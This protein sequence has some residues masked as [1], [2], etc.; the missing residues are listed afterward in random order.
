MAVRVVGERRSQPGNGE[1]VDGELVDRCVR[2]AG[3]QLADGVQ[4]VGVASQPAHGAATLD[5]RG[6]SSR[7]WT[8]VSLVG[9]GVLMGHEV[10]GVYSV[11]DHLRPHAFVADVMLYD[12]VVMPVPPGPE[13]PESP[14][15]W[16]RWRTEGWDPEA[17]KSILEI[18]GD[19]AYPV[20]WGA[21]KRAQ[22]KQE[23]LAARANEEATS[24]W[25]VTGGVLQRGLPSHVTGINAVA[26]YGS[27]A[28]L[29]EAVGLGMIT[30]TTPLPAG[31]MLVVMGRE[32][33]APDHSE[34]KSDA[35][36][37]KASVELAD[38]REFRRKRSSYWRWQREFLTDG[39][40]DQAAIKDA[41]EEMGD[42]LA[43]ELRTVRR[44]RIKTLT[45]FAFCV[46]SAAISLAAA[47]FTPLALGA[48]F[49]SVG[50]FSAERLLTAHE[51]DVP[52]P[53]ALFFDA[54]KQLGW[55]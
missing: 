11:R 25:I 18:L 3:E 46:S 17:Q 20:E 29:E 28:E 24:P 38:D 54:R 52:S 39:I 13:S 22:W 37:L 7:P 14:V 9:Q 50:Q 41:A 31:Q 32:F 44:Q 48:A 45:L 27:R 30:D 10:W 43:D 2:G 42:L 53:T 49:L 36:L 5:D 23:W 51:K 40:T 21:E 35:D 6:A 12:R 33:L 19:R 4:V 34:Y 1:V 16:Q 8:H 26:T 15:E 47:P 55:D